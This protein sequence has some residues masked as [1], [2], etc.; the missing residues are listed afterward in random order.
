MRTWMHAYIHTQMHAYVQEYRIT[1]Q[2]VNR[3]P[4][5]PEALVTCLQRALPK[6]FFD[7][8]EALMDTT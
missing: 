2:P 7:P 5:D 6:E 1:C 8:D 3:T 4:K